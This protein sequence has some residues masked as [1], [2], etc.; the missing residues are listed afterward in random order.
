MFFQSGCTKYHVECYSWHSGR[1]EKK[2]VIPYTYMYRST[3][4]ISL[5]DREIEVWEH[6]NN[7]WE[8]LKK[9][10]LFLL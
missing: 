6:E 8:H 2:R 1:Q 4:G 7:V 10:F 3:S 9:G 5:G